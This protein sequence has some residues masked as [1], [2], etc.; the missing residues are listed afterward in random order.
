MI[1]IFS[2]FLISLQTLNV[3]AQHDT[4]HVIF[5]THLDVGFTDLAPKV[6]EKYF[7]EYIPKAIQTARNL[8]K[9]GNQKFIWTTGSWIISEYLKN[10][11]PEKR[12]ELELA[13][14]DGLICWNGYPFNADNELMD[15]SLFK[16]ALNTSKDLDNFLHVLFTIP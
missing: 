8:E 3:S 14:N 10:A 12:K 13:I 9:E 11:I 5:K 1:R 7:N 15:A 16:S 2:I 4:I 6:I